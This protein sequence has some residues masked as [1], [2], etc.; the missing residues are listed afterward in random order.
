MKSYQ[1]ILIP[2]FI[3]FS[4][5]ACGGGGGGSSSNNSDTAPAMGGYTGSIDSATVSDSNKQ[6]LSKAAVDAGQKAPELENVEYVTSFTYRGSAEQNL[7]KNT[8]VIVSVVNS[9]LKGFGP[10]ESVSA[11]AKTEDI[12]G[13]ICYSGSAIYDYPESLENNPPPNSGTTK[14]TYSN[15]DMGSFFVSGL[16]MMTWNGLEQYYDPDYDEYY[17][18]PANFTVYMNLTVTMYGDAPVS[19]TA[20]VS[21]TDGGYTCTY[22]QAFS[23]SGV[24]YAISGISAYGDEIYGYNLYAQVYHQ[25]Y[26]YIYIDAMSLRYCDNGNIQSGSI[27]ITDSTGLVVLTV[28]F[29]NCDDY[30]VTDSDGVATVYPQ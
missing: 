21:C 29:S 1:S 30:T 20:S 17:Y 25:N 19:I 24:N 23:D 9:A 14:I 13:Y 6:A 2:L 22:T 3:V 10:K 11:A 8:D 27:E 7:Q 28:T 12:S 26:G 15:C 5:V 4:L 18:Y 16:S